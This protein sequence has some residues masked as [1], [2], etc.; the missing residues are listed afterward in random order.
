[1]SKPAPNDL[2]FSR[3]SVRLMVVLLSHGYRSVSELAQMSDKQLLSLERIDRAA[4]EE[5]RAELSRLERD[6]TLQ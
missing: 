2:K 6:R 3:L 5:I 4:V 1:M